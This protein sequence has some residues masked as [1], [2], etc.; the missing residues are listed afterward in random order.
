MEKQKIF[1]LLKTQRLDKYYNKFLELGIESEQDFLDSI[2]DKNLDDMGFSVAEKNRFSKLTEHIQRL[3]TAKEFEV[4][5]SLESYNLYFAFPKCQ[6]HNEITGMDPSQN[7]MEDLMLRICHQKNMDDM[8]SV[9][10][11][12]TDGLPLTDDPFF[13][14]WSLKDRH[15]ENER[16]LYAIFTPKENL[17]ESPQC[18]SQANITNE[19]PNTVR[20]HVMLKGIHEIH[21]D[22]EQSTIVDL[23]GRLSLESGIPAHVLHPKDENYSVSETL[24]DLGV[25]EEEPVY[26]TLSSFHDLVPSFNDMFISDVKPMVQQSQKGLS[27]FYSTLRAITM[28]HSGED[29]KKVIAYIRKLS[30]CN[31]LAQSLYQLICKTVNITR[32][33]KVAVVEGLYFLFRELLPSPTKRTGDKIIEDWEVFEHA[34]VCWAYLLSHGENDSLEHENYARISLKAQSTGQRFSEPVKVPGV[35]EIFDREYVLEKIKDGEKIPNCTMEN[36]KET[37]IQRE[38][39]VE[40]ILLSVPPFMD[41]F[42]LWISYAPTQPAS[43]FEI[44][45]GKT[46]AQMNQDLAKY[47]HLR[48]TPPL[49]LK[50]LGVEG[51]RLVFISEENLAIYTSKDKLTPQNIKVFDCLAGKEV[52]VNVEELANKLRDARADLTFT[53]TKTP[54]E[55]IVVLFDSS[56]SMHEECF[57]AECQMKRIDAIKQVFDSF[58]NRCMAYDFDHVICLVKFDSKVKTLHTFTENLETFKEY[59]HSLQASGNTKLYDALNH[60]VKELNKVR[61]RFTDCRCRILCLTDGNDVGST[62]KPV[63]VAKTLI[64]SNI[65]VDSVLVGKVDNTVLHGISN[66]T[67][68]FASLYLSLFLRLAKAFLLHIK[69]PDTMSSCVVGGCC[70]KPNTSKEAVQLF[71]ME[72]VLSL[73]QRKN[74]NRFDVSSLQSE[75]DLK[76]IFKRHGYDDKPEMKLPP[77]INNKVTMTQNA[78]KKKIQESK[79]NRFLDKDKRILEELKSLHCDPHPFCTV[80]PSE[81]DINAE[82]SFYFESKNMQTHVLAEEFMCSKEK[83][84]EEARKN[85]QTNAGPSIDDME[86]KYVGPELSKITLPPNLVCYLTTKLF[87]DPVKTKD[88]FTYERKAIEK[89][90]KRYVETVLCLL[91]DATPTLTVLPPSSVQLQQEKVTLVCLANKGFPSDW[92]LS[93]KVAGSSWSSGVSQ[94]SGLLQKDGL[95]SW[96]STL[97]LQKEEWLKK[98]VTCEATK[99][100][101]SP[102][103]QTLSREQC[104]EEESSVLPLPAGGGQT[105]PRDAFQGYRRLS[106]DDYLP[107]GQS[108]GYDSDDP[109][110]ERRYDTYVLPKDGFHSVLLKARHSL[111]IHPRNE[112][113]QF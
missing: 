105:P 73:E 68:L 35:P 30:G 67:G 99:D 16:K 27:V 64:T 103:T 113:T 89:H 41:A 96:S 62:I 47:E 10:L 101:Q 109:S 43:N 76:N 58:S 112:S 53:V 24:Y 49:Q 36:L 79:S 57:D 60:G 61:E 75:E 83:Y 48:I 86:K 87:V 94:S 98:T 42:P 38:T 45:T 50:P 21:V 93:W 18:P 15:I 52:T 100:S 54:K 5:K 12:T 107:P 71:E 8:T 13:N 17:K 72:T 82:T 91:G 14:T 110:N 63:D 74:K 66:V 33:Q 69:L 26:F 102:V 56:S 59:V 4:K 6:A 46:Y 28:R 78:L 32:I 1:N 111:E 31:P 104:A 3:G 37:S 108:T 9:C 34:P 23:R 25:T 85:T 55:A 7:T 97:T 70:F 19:G 90:L 20:C 29:F 39:D 11:F 84:E 77:Q 81:S 80:L 2:T 88:G 106:I 22:L 51:P 65:I 92:K 44:S 95:Y 40:R